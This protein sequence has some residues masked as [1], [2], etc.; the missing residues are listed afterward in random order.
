MAEAL[1]Y[2]LE[3]VANSAEQVDD[4]QQWLRFIVGVLQRRAADVTPA[5]AP[6]PEPSPL[7]ARD[8][9]ERVTVAKRSLGCHPYGCTVSVAKHSPVSAELNAGQ[10]YKA[11]SACECGHRYDQH[12]LDWQACH[13]CPCNG[14]RY[15]TA[16]RDSN[17]ARKWRQDRQPTGSEQTP[18]TA[19]WSC[20]A[21]L[22]RP[23][24][25]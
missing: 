21:T 1:A 25:P 2:L 19:C 22:P 20:G 11:N 17:S 10:D 7:E 24:K 6:K 9:A 16:T 15:Y 18:P 13:E 3:R 14:F 4:A 23:E 8:I 5:N 12:A